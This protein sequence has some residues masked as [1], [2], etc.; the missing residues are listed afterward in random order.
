MRCG[1]LQSR[2]KECSDADGGLDVR[3]SSTTPVETLHH[4]FHRGMEE[5][6]G[7]RYVRLAM[8]RKIPRDVILASCLRSVTS[9]ERNFSFS[10]HFYISYGYLACEKE[11]ERKRDSRG[12]G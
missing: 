2:D 8:R 3:E 1:A 4:E 6:G 11:N 12:F 10:P 5:G 7:G 9:W